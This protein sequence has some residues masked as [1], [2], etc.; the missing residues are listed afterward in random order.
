MKRDLKAV[1]G[2]QQ[3]QILNRPLIIFLQSLHDVFS[4]KRSKCL[5][6]AL[7]ISY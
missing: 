4:I 6:L 1:V 5:F 7:L 2:N 3:N